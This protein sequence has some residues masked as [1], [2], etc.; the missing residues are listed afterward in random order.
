MPEAVPWLTQVQ[1][2]SPQ[3]LALGHGV[4]ELCSALGVTMPSLVLGLD[5]TP[6]PC[7]RQEVSPRSA[8]WGQGGV[9]PP[10]LS[11]LPSSVHLSQCPKTRH[12]GLFPGFPGSPEGG[13]ARGKFF[14]WY[15]WGDDWGRILASSLLWLP[16]ND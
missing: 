2:L 4:V 15:L 5:L 6:S 12:H 7:P 8:A 14:N 3:V 1:R 9:G 16:L 13:L 11:F 10:A